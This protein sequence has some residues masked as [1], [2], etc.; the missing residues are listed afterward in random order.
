M[1][2]LPWV[3]REAILL[4]SIIVVGAVFINGAILLAAFVVG[5]RDYL[6]ASRRKRTLR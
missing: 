2:D 4:V 5:L 1:N 6:R 3:V